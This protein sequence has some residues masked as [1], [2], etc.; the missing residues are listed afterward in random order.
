MHHLQPMRRSVI[1]LDMPGLVSDLAFGGRPSRGLPWAAANRE[2][3]KMPFHRPMIPTYWARLLL[4][5]WAM[6]WEAG[7]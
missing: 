5:A 3:R 6:A 1:C 2:I 4:M 7:G